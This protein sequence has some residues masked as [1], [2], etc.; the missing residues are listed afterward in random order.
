MPTS[1]ISAP[2][3]IRQLHRSTI[4]GSLPQ[5]KRS[6]SPSAKTAASIALIVA[7]TKTLSKTKC[8]PF[9]RPLLEALI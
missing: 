5:L 2:I 9:K 8:V 1:V 6:V 4:S 3:L 7:P